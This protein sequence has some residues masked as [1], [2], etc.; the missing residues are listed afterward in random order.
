[1]RNLADNPNIDLE[2]AYKLYLENDSEIYFRLCRNNA[3]PK[4]VLIDIIENDA[5]FMSKNLMATAQHPNAD[6]EILSILYDKTVKR[7]NDLKPAY[8]YSAETEATYEMTYLLGNP[9][10]DIALIDKIVNKFP[11]IIQKINNG[12]KRE[13]KRKQIE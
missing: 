7:L 8:G 1:M 10:I 9:N 5:G 3:T 13:Q 6:N 4:S 12:D 11:N 2:L